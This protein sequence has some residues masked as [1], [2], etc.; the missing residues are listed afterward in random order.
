MVMTDVC[1]LS[2]LFLWSGPYFWRIQRSGSLVSFQ[3]ALITNFWIG[4]PLGTD[5]IDAVY[6]R[7]S[8][9][10]IIFFIGL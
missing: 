3:P 2:S 6:E 7:K 10:K 9:S 8:D 5:K 1:Q 4:L